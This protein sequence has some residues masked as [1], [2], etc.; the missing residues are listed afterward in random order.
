MGSVQYNTHP[1]VLFFIK[2]LWRQGDTRHW[3]EVF[4]YVLPHPLPVVFTSDDV[5]LLKVNLVD[6]K[7]TH[8][9]LLLLL[10]LQAERGYRLTMSCCNNDTI[11]IR[12][13]WRMGRKASIHLAEPLLPGCILHKSLR[14]K[15]DPIRPLHNQDQLRSQAQTKYG[16]RMR[17]Q[18][19]HAT[20]YVLSKLRCMTL[21]KN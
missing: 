7:E 10:N 15:T 14:T 6:S 19:S 20:T 21:V 17:A 3:S 13:G 8:D 9:V 1:T 12:F 4:R 5:T 18:C 11:I 2:Y 16:S